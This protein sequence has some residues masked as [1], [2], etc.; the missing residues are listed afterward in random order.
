MRRLLLTLLML[1]SL[2]AAARPPAGEAGSAQPAPAAATSPPPPAAVAPPA[3]PP[4][5]RHLEGL[6]RTPEEEAMLRD[7]SHALQ[8]YE[9]EARDFRHE[10]QLLVERKY[11]EKRAGLAASYEKVIGE[12]EIK[13]RKERLD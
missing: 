5:R 12:L 13:E 10:V 2:T 8:E 3:Q 6:G 1:T 7:I 9:E 4:E 11:E